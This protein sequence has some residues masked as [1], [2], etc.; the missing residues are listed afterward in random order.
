MG[1]RRSTVRFR[2]GSSSEHYF[3]LDADVDARVLI[4]HAADRRKPRHDCQ[5]INLDQAGLTDAVLNS[6]DLR[7]AD[8]TGVYL[9]SAHLYGANLTEAAL[10]GADL[11]G[12]FLTHADLRDADLRGADFGEVGVSAFGLGVNFLGVNFTGAHWPPDEVVPTG[13]QRDTASGRLKRADIDPGGA[14]TDPAPGPKRSPP[15]RRTEH[16]FT[17]ISGW[18][19]PSFTSKG[20][21]DCAAPACCASPSMPSPRGR[22]SGMLG[23][24][25]LQTPKV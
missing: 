9:R 5:P 7:G 16:L 19:A 4:I 10:S 25:D 17:A 3:D 21:A 2:K 12:A 1:R 15:G 8:L 18:P 6:T 20:R 23:A 14:A 11:R 24:I 13:W 22:R